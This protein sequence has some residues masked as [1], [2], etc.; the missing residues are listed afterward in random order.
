VLPPALIPAHAQSRGFDTA[1]R[2]AQKQ[3]PFKLA[4][5]EEGYRHLM[6]IKTHQEKFF[7]ENHRAPSE[8]E[9]AAALGMRPERVKEL[10]AWDELR[11]EEANSGMDELTHAPSAEDVFEKKEEEEERQRAF[12]TVQAEAK[13]LPDIQRKVAVAIMG[14]GTVKDGAQRIGISTSAFYR[15]KDKARRRLKKLKP[16]WVKFGKAFQ[17]MR[18]AV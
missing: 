12:E 8:E 15:E 4:N 7:K 3:G 11:R 13:K 9:I 1:K 6:K 10:L 16:I 17:V 5:P 14:Q 18:S 2:W